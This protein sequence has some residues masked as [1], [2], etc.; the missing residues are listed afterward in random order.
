MPERKKENPGRKKHL[1]PST[2]PHYAVGTID[3]TPGKEP[4]MML[5]P[6]LYRM[7]AQAQQEDVQREAE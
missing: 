5:D 2:C 7:V 6:P 4:L 3:P 1:C